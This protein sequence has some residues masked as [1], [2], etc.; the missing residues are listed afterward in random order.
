MFLVL[1]EPF[2]KD[3]LIVRFIHLVIYNIDNG[4]DFFQTLLPH[5]I[6]TE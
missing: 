3:V 6:P 4:S 1:N 5:P 2:T